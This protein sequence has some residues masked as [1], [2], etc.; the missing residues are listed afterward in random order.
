[1]FETC[2]STSANHETVYSRVGT[3]FLYF[4]LETSTISLTIPVTVLAETDNKV[5]AAYP[6]SHERTRRI[7]KFDNSFNPSIP[8]TWTHH[9]ALATGASGR[10][11]DNLSRQSSAARN[12]PQF[13]VN[14]FKGEFNPSAQ[15]RRRWRGRTDPTIKNKKLAVSC[16]KKTRKLVLFSLY[17]W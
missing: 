11:S 14:I 5:R 12:S 3:T 15:N 4:L 1:M 7:L 8:E 9:T 2:T 13:P 6:L 16:L 17:L 10:A